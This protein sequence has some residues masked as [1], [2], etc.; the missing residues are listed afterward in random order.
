MTQRLLHHQKATQ[1]WV[2]AHVSWRGWCLFQ[3]AQLASASSGQLS[4]SDCLSA[5]LAAYVHLRLKGLENFVGFRKLRSCLLPKFKELPCTVECFTSLQTILSVS[6]IPSKTECFILEEI[7]MPKIL[8][9]PANT[10]SLLPFPTSAKICHYSEF[11]IPRCFLL[12]ILHPL[13]PLSSLTVS[14]HFSVLYSEW[15]PCLL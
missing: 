8:Q 14:L 15:S 2:T 11:S 4:L 3:A 5:V 6:Q 12:V 13:T 10:K 7:A 9:A 1:A